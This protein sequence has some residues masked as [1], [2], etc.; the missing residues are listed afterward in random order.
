MQLI[1]DRQQALGKDAWAGVYN[2]SIIPAG[3]VLTE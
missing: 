2:K 3:Y 1:G